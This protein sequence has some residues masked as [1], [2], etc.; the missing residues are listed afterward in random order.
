MVVSM[1]DH[2]DA[3]VS[4]ERHPLLGFRPPP[5]DVSAARQ[6]LDQH[7]PQWS[8]T[9]YLE[10]CLRW[11]AEEPKTALTAVMP[12]AGPRVQ[13]ERLATLVRDKIGSGEIAGRLPPAAQLAKTYQVSRNTVDRA[14]TALADEGVIASRGPRLGYDVV[15]RSEWRRR[16]QVTAPH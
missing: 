16:H 10:A 9:A 2:R 13:H 14:L 7:D 4:A 1:T 12:W 6:R 8:I 15:P 3:A 5:G 11:L